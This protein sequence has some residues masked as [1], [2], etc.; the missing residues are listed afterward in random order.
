MGQELVEK[1]RNQKLESCDLAGSEIRNI[2]RIL[3]R[4]NEKQSCSHGEP[5][6]RK[7]SVVEGLGP[8]DCTGDVRGAGI[9]G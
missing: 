8:S 4:K 3:S 5:A 7:N 6:G 2:I 1:A 9:K